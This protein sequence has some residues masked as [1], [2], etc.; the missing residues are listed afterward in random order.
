MGNT[1]EEVEAARAAYSSRAGSGAKYGKGQGF[2]EYV[3]RFRS[4]TNYPGTLLGEIPRFS[5]TISTSPRWRVDFED[6]ANY[7]GSASEYFI[8]PEYDVQIYN[9]DYY[10]LM[11]KNVDPG[12][13]VCSWRVGSMVQ[14][15]SSHATSNI[16]Q[17][18][19][20]TWFGLEPDWDNWNDEIGAYYPANWRHKIDLANVDGNG[21]YTALFNTTDASRGYFSILHESRHN[22]GYTTVVPITDSTYNWLSFDW[23]MAANAS[24]AAAAADIPIYMSG[25]ELTIIKLF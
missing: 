15:I 25:Y 9:P 24:T 23:T 20:Q 6:P 16:F 3:V 8:N 21:L 13:Y 10:P 22:L 19:F 7:V 14:G 5:N 18:S 12:L 1:Q 11:I 4:E 17:V 2:G